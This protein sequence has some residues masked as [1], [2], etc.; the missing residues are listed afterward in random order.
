MG[1]GLGGKG[2]SL[3]TFQNAWVERTL[4]DHN[5]LEGRIYFSS[6][7]RSSISLC[8]HT[9]Q[10][11]SLVSLSDNRGHELNS[12]QRNTGLQ[13]HIPLSPLVATEDST[14]PAGD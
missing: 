5:P 13:Q 10:L 3:G 4:K 7:I 2:Q 6:N 11:H 8:G 14:A 1:R 9:A 12:S